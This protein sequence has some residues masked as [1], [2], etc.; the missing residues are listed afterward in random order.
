MSATT[1]SDEIPM[2]I[3]SSPSEGSF[4]CS[5]GPTTPSSSPLFRPSEVDELKPAQLAPSRVLNETDQLQEGVKN[6]CVVGAGYVGGP[7]AA[8]LALYHPSIKVEVLDRDPSRIQRWQSPH[9]PV[10][11]PGL[12]TVV[13][14]VRDGAFIESHT[15]NS[16]PLIGETSAPRRQ[17]NLFFTCNSAQAISRADIILMA[18]NTPTKMFGVGAGCATNMTA[19]DGAMR[20]VA[21]YARPGAIIVEKSTVPAGTAERVRKMLANRRPGV[22]F[23]VLS[24]PE[25][26]AEGSAIENLTAPDRV[27]IGSAA[28]PSGHQ[29]AQ[30][31]ASL[32]TAWVPR[33]RILT[34]NAWSSELAKLVANA[35]LA[36]RISSI[37]SISV[38]CER[39]GA[40]VGQ[41]AKA[42]GMD[43][44]IGPQFLK[45][46][47]GF[48]GSCFRKDI[49]SLAYLAE[50]LGLDDVAHYWRQ[51]NVMNERQCNRFS[52]KIID[53]F[54]GNLVGHKLAML[55]F[56]FKKNTG[57]TRE[58][59]A[60][61]V[62]RVLLE[63]R[64]AEIAIF[65]PYCHPEDILR[66]LKEVCPGPTL[67]QTVKI[68]TDPYLAC[69][70]ANAVL[71]VTDCDQFRNFPSQKLPAPSISSNP[72]GLARN[73]TAETCNEDVKRPCARSESETWAHAGVSYQLMPQEV[74]VADCTDCRLTSTRPTM[75]SIEWP[76]IA[77]NMVEPKWVFDGRG[78]LDAEELEK[79]GVRV[80]VVG[81]QPSLDSL[82]GII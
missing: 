15:S 46:G 10:H 72:K 4:S 56:A 21:A 67:G 65:D 79:L 2:D 9:L 59:L 7:T 68:V 26:L 31:L 16:T 20:D 3:L 41:V 53:R 23:E 33:S 49:A 25:F 44:R 29:A 27:L 50:S 38:I 34:T 81:R 1:P 74:C 36:Q 78:L 66:E 14:I 42:I 32:Y 22:P 76:R 58:S 80:D 17:Q 11:E 39:T 69:S 37:N 82:A 47:L 71:V 24:N 45:A 48:G 35:M 6:V 43:G 75:E 54:E 52:R 8:V 57:D 28:T 5:T 55:G 19:F 18:V 13:R 60:V 30:I 77:Y 40:E 61:E 51:V 73:I 62:I 63:E 12:D 70:Q 64:P